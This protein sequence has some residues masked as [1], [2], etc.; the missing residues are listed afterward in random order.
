MKCSHEDT[1]KEKG[2][3][4][5]VEREIHPKQG[6]QESLGHGWLGKI[7]FIAILRVSRMSRRTLDGVGRKRTNA[8][9]ERVLRQGLVGRM[10]ERSCIA[11]TN[12]PSWNRTERGNGPKVPGDVTAQC[13][14]TNEPIGLTFCSHS[15]KRRL[16]TLSSPSS[17]LFRLLL[18]LSLYPVY[19]FFASSFPLFTIV[20]SVFTKPHLSFL[21]SFLPSFLPLI[22]SCITFF[23]HNHKPDN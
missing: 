1:L 23:Y 18:P 17:S 22:L 13:S 12:E 19:I 5:F 16:D 2:R 11:T 4:V 14:L 20:L 10:Q 15:F 21:T 7:S 8:T 3:I 9:L 6:F